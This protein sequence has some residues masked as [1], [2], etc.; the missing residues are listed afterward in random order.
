MMTTQAIKG[1]T[2]PCPIV[3][4]GAARR[5]IDTIIDFFSAYLI[6]KPLFYSLWVDDEPEV[7]TPFVTADVAVCRSASHRG[8][9]AVRAFWDP[10]HDEMA[11]RFDWTIDEFIVGADPDV[12]VTRSAS[13]IDVET[14]PAWGH[15]HVVYNGRYVQIFRFRDGK[16]RSFEEYYDT[17]LLN[18]AYA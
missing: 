13:A 18:K 1:V 10:I 3:A 12:I 11:G 17:A 15:R 4:T 14:G 8:W 2:V 16:V 6:D 9:D 7:I 5:N